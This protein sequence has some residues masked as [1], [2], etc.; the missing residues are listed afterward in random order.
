MP[1]RSHDFRI[2]GLSGCTDVAGKQRRLFEVLIH[3]T[4]KGTVMERVFFAAEGNTE[5]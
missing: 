2:S 3:S 4:E 1:F 5:G